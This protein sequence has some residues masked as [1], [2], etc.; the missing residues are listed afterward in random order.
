[1]AHARGGLRAPRIGVVAEF[2]EPRGLGVVRDDGGGSY[3]FHCASIA[4]GT[5]RI[6]AGTR[7]VFFLAAG[8]LG[9]YEA[10]AV[11][12]VAGGEGGGDGADEGADK[13][14]GEGADKGGGEGADKGGG[15]GT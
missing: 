9:R 2:D 14:G 1:M 12:S 11:T 7:V 5:R 4:N 13:G 8:H 6:D 3:P 10:R 15:E